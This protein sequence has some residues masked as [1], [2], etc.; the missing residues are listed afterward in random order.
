V[1][2]SGDEAQRIVDLIDE[3]YAQEDRESRARRYIGASGIGNKCDAT[4]AFALRGFPDVQPSPRLKRI[5]ALGHILEDIVVRDLKRKAKLAVLEVD[6]MTGKQFHYEVFGGH[7]R[8][9][10]DGLIEQPNG[11]VWNLEVKSMNEASWAKFKEKGVKYSHPHYYDQML[12]QMGLSGV[13]T[14]LFIA[15]NKNTSLYHAEV[16]TFDDM[17]WEF[18]KARIERVLGNQARKLASDESDWRC[19]GCF[20]AGVCWQGVKAKP[21]CATCQD[22]MATQNGK[23]ACMRHYREVAPDDV[24]S[25]FNQYA[26]LPKE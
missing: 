20:K 11:D 8:A 5:F 24:C 19:R 13:T 2:G 16:V 25:D 3:G 14:S 15:Y 17:E 22:A 9:N 1:A 21:A 26:P 12:M 7:V 6:P 10:L 4:L 18:L 23:W